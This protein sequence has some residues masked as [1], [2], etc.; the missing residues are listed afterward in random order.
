MVWCYNYCGLLENARGCEADTYIGVVTDTLH[1]A[2]AVFRLETPQNEI[3][4]VYPVARI[5]YLPRRIASSGPASVPTLALTYEVVRYTL[6]NTRDFRIWIL[7]IFPSSYRLCET[8][9]AVTS[10][11]F[12]FKSVLLYGLPRFEAAI[13]SPGLEGGL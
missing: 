11:R 12:G 6:V 8:P 4:P 5:L 3:T 10:G 1:T 7:D 9:I 13:T 2:R